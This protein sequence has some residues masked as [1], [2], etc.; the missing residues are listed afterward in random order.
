MVWRAGECRAA[1]LPEG[2]SASCA[3][4]LAS[5]PAATQGGVWPAG[6]G[7]S[8]RGG[9]ARLGGQSLVGRNVQFILVVGD[10]RFQID[11]LVSP[12]VL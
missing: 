3:V 11:P 1:V 7:W 5:L 12:S 2:R 6:G 4:P 10:S 8:R 9:V